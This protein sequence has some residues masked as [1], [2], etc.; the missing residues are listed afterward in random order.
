MQLDLLYEE[1]LYT[2]VNRVGVPSPE[3]VTADE[4]L[5]TYLY[6]VQYYKIHYYR[7]VPSMV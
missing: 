6:K 5:F 4:D 1:A 2:V 7:V 3:Y